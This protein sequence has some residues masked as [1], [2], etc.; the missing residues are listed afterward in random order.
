MRKLVYEFEDKETHKK[1]EISD[2]VEFLNLKRAIENGD[3][4]L[5]YID[6]KL[7]EIK[8]IMD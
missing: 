1:I 2:Y 4:N 3:S 5:E 6:R 7:I 8:N